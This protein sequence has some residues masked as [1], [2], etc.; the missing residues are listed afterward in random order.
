MKAKAK[1]AF[2]F[3]FAWSGLTWHII[4]G[5]IFFF[6][7]FNMQDLLI[8]YTARHSMY[9]LYTWTNIYV[10]SV[11]SPNFLQ[12]G[13]IQRMY[14]YLGFV[15]LFKFKGN[16]DH[17]LPFSNKNQNIIYK[18][19]NKVVFHIR[20]LICHVNLRL[21]LYSNKT[22][23]YTH[24][25]AHTHSHTHVHTLTLTHTHTH[26]HINTHIHTRI[27]TILKSDYD[28]L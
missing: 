9:I 4:G 5:R 11:K 3:A 6:S 12:S 13:K 8:I 21:V 16:K 27:V 22:H 26:T 14:Q 25:P 1:I 28:T 24:T 2:F 17:Y 20:I 15:F 23:M 18:F 19:E 7:A 10:H